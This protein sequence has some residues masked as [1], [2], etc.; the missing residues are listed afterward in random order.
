MKRGMFHGSGQLKK[1]QLGRETRLRR[2]LD[3]VGVHVRNGV[4]YILKACL[5]I[6]WEGKSRPLKR[7]RGGNWK[8]LKK[9]QTFA[10]T[11]KKDRKAAIEQSKEGHIRRKKSPRRIEGNEKEKGIGRE[12]TT[13]RKKRD[14]KELGGKFVGKGKKK[15]TITG[16]KK[17]AKG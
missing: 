2:V 17:Q 6:W 15:V 7:G 14:G 8:V 4:V 16:K 5:V 9:R 12:G 10:K 1:N 11:I 13:E 3:R